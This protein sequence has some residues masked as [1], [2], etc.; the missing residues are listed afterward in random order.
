MPDS[1]VIGNALMAKLGAHAPLLAL[2]PNGVSEDIAIG[3]STKYVTVS[4]IV[5]LD[6]DIF[7]AR[8][9]EEHHYEILARGPATSAAD[10]HGAAAIIDN[11]LAPQPPTPPA[12]LTVAGYS[13][14]TITREEFLRG[15]EFDDIDKSI[16][17]IHR[18]GRYLV[19]CSL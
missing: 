5:S 3:G 4:L 12:T 8:G 17:R 15:R 13:L 7:N 9:Y 11:L 16:I 18:G 10:V 14:M 2:M 19:A 1:S 6:T